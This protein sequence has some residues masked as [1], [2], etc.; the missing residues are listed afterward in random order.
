VKVLHLT[1]LTAALVLLALPAQAQTTYKIQP[2]VA[3]GDTIAG[4]RISGGLG[5]CALGDTGDLLFIAN[6]SSGGEALFYAAN[7]TFIPIAL[8]GQDAPGGKWPKGLDLRPAAMNSRGT[9]VF[10]GGVTMGGVTGWGIFRWDRTTQQ[11]TPVALPGT[12][13]VNGLTFLTGPIPDYPAINNRDEIAFSLF[14]QDA[15]GKAQQAAFF[16]G[17][18]GK[19]LPIV[20]PDQTLP[21]GKRMLR[22]GIDVSVNDPGMA[23]FRVRREGDAPDDTSA[24][25]WD[26]SGSLT[27]IAVVGEAAPGGGTIARVSVVYLNNKDRSAL[28]VASTS[29]QP[30]Q[31]GLYRFTEGRLTPLLVPGEE[32]PG[33]G[34]LKTIPQGATAAGVWTKISRANEAGQHVFI[35]ELEGGEQGL[36]RLEPSTRETGGAQLSLILKSGTVT[37]WGTIGLFPVPQNGVGLNNR[38]Q[39][40]LSVHFVGG[41][42]RMV[43]LTPLAP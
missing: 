40:A 17:A 19:L 24:Y 22:A 29:T 15:A 42:D 7:G 20:L 43:L 34:K 2:I 33:G 6:P 35:A 9:A 4:V 18:D 1:G 38:G 36:Y 23:A 21:D 27:S 39:V 26:L 32:M 41:R 31:R 8:G 3:I 30:K 10:A 14:V 11:V 25:L 12:P 5:A 37:E 13:A 16:V 28:V